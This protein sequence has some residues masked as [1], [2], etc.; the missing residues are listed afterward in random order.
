MNTLLTSR[1]I[2]S[3]GHGLSHDTPLT[4]DSTVFYTAV[5]R[6]FPEIS[7]KSSKAISGIVSTR[8]GRLTPPNLPLARGGAAGGGVFSFQEMS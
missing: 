6:L 8:C 2:L 1:F 5:F 4:F 7:L 3:V